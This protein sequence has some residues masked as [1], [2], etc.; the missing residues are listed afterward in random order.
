M[1]SSPMRLTGPRLTRL[2][3]PMLTGTALAQIEPTNFGARLLQDTRN[4]WAHFCKFEFINRSGAPIFEV[5][6][7]QRTSEDEVHAQ[8]NFRPAIS[9]VTSKGPFDNSLSPPGWLVSFRSEWPHDGTAGRHWSLSW[10]AASKALELEPGRS[11]ELT[12]SM[13]AQEPIG[14][15]QLQWSAKPRLDYPPAL[16]AAR[17]AAIAPQQRRSDEEVHK[18]NSQL[19]RGQAIQRDPVCGNYGWCEFETIFLDPQGNV[20]KIVEWTEGTER[21]VPTARTSKSPI[22]LRSVLESYYDTDG[23]FIFMSGRY[24][25]EPG[26]GSLQEHTVYVEGGIVI[27]SLISERSS[28]PFRPEPPGPRDDINARARARFDAAKRFV[29]THRP[30]PR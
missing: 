19:G 16:V 29:E 13:H 5:T 23:H 18:V 26:S 8:L 1:S 28:A 22:I 17:D 15:P 11:L 10:Q 9:S 2:L 25:G 30:N 24:E 14:C 12:V 7:G 27:R 3:L 20:R 4:D 6:A 21:R